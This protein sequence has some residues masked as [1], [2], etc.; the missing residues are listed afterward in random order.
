MCPPQKSSPPVITG[1]LCHVPKGVIVL[2]LNCHSSQRCNL[3]ILSLRIDNWNSI[4]GKKLT[5]FPLKTISRKLLSILGASH[6]INCMYSLSYVQSLAK[7]KQFENRNSVQMVL[8][9]PHYS[10]AEFDEGKGHIFI[11]S[12][13]MISAQD[14]DCEVN[15][16][17]A[18]WA[19]FQIILNCLWSKCPV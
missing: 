8:Q 14:T 13:E 12:L 17:K 5:D 16:R 7:S 2:I 18:I 1:K 9:D 4:H 15:S 3:I 6:I 19:S 10:L 11:T